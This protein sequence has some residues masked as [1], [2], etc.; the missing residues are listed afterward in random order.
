[1]KMRKK[2]IIILA[3]IFIVMLFLNMI[4]PLIMDDFNYTYGL[5]GKTNSIKDILEY[6]HWFYFNWGGRTVAHIFAQFF[7]MNN[8]ILFNFLN[9]G[10]FTL[11]VYLIYDIIKGE[12]QHHP[13]YLI[14]IFFFLWFITPAFGQAFVWLTGSCNYL[15]TTTIMLIFLNTFIHIAET[16]KK[17]SKLQIILFGILGIIAGW[18]NENSGASLVFMLHAYVFM[19]KRIIC[20]LLY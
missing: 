10:M 1:M 14:L 2:I 11:M 15:W 20:N 17:Y 16:E 5:E 6:Q 12:K 3:C 19:K 7:L 4:T 9:A 18:T 8:K 13:I